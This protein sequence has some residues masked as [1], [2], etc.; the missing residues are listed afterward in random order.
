MGERLQ[1]V[2]DSGLGKGQASR[3][4]ERETSL[5]IVCEPA[6]THRIAVLKLRV[7]RAARLIRGQSTVGH[8]EKVGVLV[9]TN[10]LEES[11]KGCVGWD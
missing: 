2:V 11:A 3:L 1:A 9:G 6:E 10:G 7:E 8:L 4:R 5:C